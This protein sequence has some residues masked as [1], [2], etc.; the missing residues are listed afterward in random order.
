MTTEGA[1]PPLSNSIAFTKAMATDRIVVGGLEREPWCDNLMAF[2]NY[3]TTTDVIAA[4]IAA[5][6]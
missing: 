3:G 2:E 6:L 4:I 1:L 5:V